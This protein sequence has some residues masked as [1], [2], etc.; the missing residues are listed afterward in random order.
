MSPLGKGSGGGVASPGANGRCMGASV[1]GW[2][3]TRTP[4]FL[5]GPRR[6]VLADTESGGKAQLPKS[7]KE[8]CQKCQNK[9]QK[10]LGKEVG[11]SITWRVIPS[12]SG[13]VAYAK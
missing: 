8:K 3:N 1:R 12:S 2:S 10:R 13:K 9:D 6:T 11:I 4:G 5:W 7:R